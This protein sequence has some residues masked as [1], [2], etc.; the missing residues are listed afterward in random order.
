MAIA[1]RH[2]SILFLFCAPAASGKSTVC[3]HLL[4]RDARLQRSISTTTRLPR[5]G[6]ADGKDYYFVSDAEFRRRVKD[7]CFTE[8]AEFGGYL[9]G[10]EKRN[11]ENADSSGADLLL[12]LDV[13]GVAQVKRLYP[14]K[15]VTIFIFPP[16]FQV[17]EERLQSRGTDSPERQEQ[18][19]ALALG[20]LKQLRSEGFS[21]YLLINDILEE[22]IVAAQEIISAER[23]KFSRQNPKFIEKL[24][25]GCK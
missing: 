16:S 1:S 6:E 15:V 8:Y 19:L 22:S 2:N 9:Y 3:R 4:E 24:F 7:A 12:D 5:D 14:E 18:R 11:I 20:E 21:D 25:T 23:Q 13:Q 10:T 17:L